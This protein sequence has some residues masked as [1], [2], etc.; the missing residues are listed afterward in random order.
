MRDSARRA[1]RVSDTP[2]SQRLARPDL[3]GTNCA[4]CS[5][6]SLLLVGEEAA[7]GGAALVAEELGVDALVGGVALAGGL[8]DAVAVLLLGLVVSGVVLGLGH[9]ALTIK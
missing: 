1:R 4:T 6:C 5:T 2:R 3:L 9:S 8:P 7:L